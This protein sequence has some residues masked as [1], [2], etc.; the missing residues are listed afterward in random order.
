MALLC[1]PA[2]CDQIKAMGGD[3]SGWS[4]SIS[5]PSIRL[6]LSI[7]G[8]CV[9]IAVRYVP[10]QSAKAAILGHGGCKSVAER[11]FAKANVARF[12]LG[13]TLS[14]PAIAHRCVSCRE[15]R[16]RYSDYIKRTGVCASRKPLT[17]SSSAPKKATRYVDFERLAISPQ[18]GFASTV[19]GNP[20]TEADVRAKLVVVVQA[21]KNAF[22]D[23]SRPHVGSRCLNPSRHSP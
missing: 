11:L 6:S 18:C 19:A 4:T 21:A 14:V 7:P 23:N 22:G 5:M 16:A 20:L 1:D 13:M 15:A 2:I 17:R 12:L 3:Q 10:R 9:V 8:R